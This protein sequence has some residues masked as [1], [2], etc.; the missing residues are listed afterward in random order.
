MDISLATWLEPPSLS[1]AKSA[2]RASSALLERTQGESRRSLYSKRTDPGR[3]LYQVDPLK[4]ERPERLE[5]RHRLAFDAHQLR[6]V[7]WWSPLASPSLISKAAEECTVHREARP[8][9]RL[10]ALDDRGAQHAVERKNLV[11]RG[12]DRRAVVVLFVRPQSSAGHAFTKDIDVPAET[13]ACR[14]LARSS[15]RARGLRRAGRTAIIN[16]LHGCRP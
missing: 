12:R 8:I 11:E 6:C 3:A 1:A 2:T 16:A 4:D 13:A 14:V 15:L 10:V 5:H 7:A 9:I